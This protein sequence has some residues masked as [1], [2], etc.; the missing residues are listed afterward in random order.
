[1]VRIEPPL[2]TI[3]FGPRRPAARVRPAPLRA[4]LGLNRGRRLAQARRDRGVMLAAEPW[5]QR[6]HTDRRS[7]L[8]RSDRAPATPIAAE[9]TS[10]SS[11]AYAR[12]VS[13]IMARRDRIPLGINGRSRRHRQQWPLEDPVERGHG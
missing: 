8:R 1:M 2:N 9:A 10:T 13:R 3:G 11:G 12:P 7:Q 4:E 5:R 6:H